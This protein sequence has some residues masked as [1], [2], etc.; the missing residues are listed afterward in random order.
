M[1]KLSFKLVI[2]SMLFMYMSGRSD[3][4]SIQDTYP[5]IQYG[6]AYALG[7]FIKDINLQ[8][9]G[10]I[11]TMMRVGQDCKMRVT[12]S[13]FKNH[14]VEIKPDSIDCVNP[15]ISRNLSEKY[16]SLA[17]VNVEQQLPSPKDNVRFEVYVNSWQ[18]IPK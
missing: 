1:R 13:K 5:K 11:S 4:V 7:S 12:V 8:K 9:V 15:E 3:G 10:T 16:V 6:K 14:S 2:C 17:Y 18:D